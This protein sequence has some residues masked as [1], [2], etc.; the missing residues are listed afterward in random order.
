MMSSYKIGFIGCGNMGGAIVHGIIKG[1]VFD[2]S[3]ICACDLNQEKIKSLGVTPLDTPEEICQNSDMILIAV[4]PKVAPD[5]LANLHEHLA[6]K[7]LI[8]IV[9]GFSTQKIQEFSHNKCRVL[10]VMPNTPA[11]VGAGAT[12][13]SL[14]TSFSEAEKKVAEQIFTATGLFAW[15]EESLM[16]AVTAVSGS[17]PAYAFLFLEALADGGVREGL[18]RDVAYRLAAQT[19][20]GAAQMVLQTGKH[21]GELK[22]MVCSPAG[23]T[24]DAVYA[25]EQGGLRATV[26]DAVHVCAQKSKELGKK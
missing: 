5:L 21:P 13:L 20:V 14:A 19:L 1:G 16:D 4:K 10:R 2:A 24:I 26:I 25:L 7:A 11:M 6:G 3:E 18:P 15:V 17:G 9:A 12:A 22:D 23:T 8:S